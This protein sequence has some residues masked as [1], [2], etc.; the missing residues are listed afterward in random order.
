VPADARVAWVEVRAVGIRTRVVPQGLSPDGTITPPQG[1]AIW[2]TGYGRVMPGRVGT[3]VVAGHVV[4]YGRPDVFAHL[5]DVRPGARVRVGYRDGAV[6]DLTVVRTKVVDKA[7][8][9]SDPDV[10]GSGV[11]TRRVVLITCDDALGFRAD[12]H[13]VANFVAVA[14]PA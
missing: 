2:F 4:A 10:W 7:H 9:S 8:L 14:E 12:G 3:A 13:R 6:L 5:P 1:T 11:R